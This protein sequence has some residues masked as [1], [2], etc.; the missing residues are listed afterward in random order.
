MDFDY[1]EKHSTS[2]SNKILLW[3]CSEK[4]REKLIG[5]FWELFPKKKAFHGEQMFDG[6]FI[7]GMFCLEETQGD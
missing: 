2:L 3:Q 4:Q 5:N 7:G 6:K 1:C